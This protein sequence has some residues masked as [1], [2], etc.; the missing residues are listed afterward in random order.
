MLTLHVDMFA[1]LPGKVFLGFL[2]LPSVIATVSGVVLYASFMRRLDL[3]MVR[4][5]SSSKVKWL[6]L[7]NLLGAV[8]I[9][10]ILV[11]G[12][13]WVINIWADLVPQLWRFDQLAE[14]VESYQ[15][16][17]PAGHF[18]SPEKRPCHSACRCTRHD[19][20]PGRNSA[21]MRCLSISEIVSCL[22]RGRGLCSS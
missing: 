2:G 16:E 8:T 11:V 15:D 20:F 19:A 7:H 3:S 4:R 12:F 6:D 1:G 9:I 10:W 21:V 14:M 5:Q 17:P 18:A 13:T 22:A